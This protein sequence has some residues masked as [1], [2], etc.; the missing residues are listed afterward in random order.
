VREHFDNPWELTK[1][2]F[3]EARDAALGAD[4][5]V[6]DL[7]KELGGPVEPPSRLAVLE[8]EIPF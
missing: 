7:L 2:L 8:D 5:A 4:K 3:F 1:A 6:E